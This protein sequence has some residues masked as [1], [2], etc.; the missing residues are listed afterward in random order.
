MLPPVLAIGRRRNAATFKTSLDLTSISFRC[1]N[2][3]FRSNWEMTSRTHTEEG[4]TVGDEEIHGNARVGDDDEEPV[5][6]PER[7]ER[8]ELLV[9]VVEPEH[10]LGKWVKKGNEPGNSAISVC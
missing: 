3:S 1:Q 9:Q 6:E 2:V 7:V 5:V 10:E 4:G 8:L